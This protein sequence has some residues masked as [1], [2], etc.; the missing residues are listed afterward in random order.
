MNGVI[1]S[2][3]ALLALTKDDSCVPH[4]RQVETMLRRGVRFI[5]FRSKML[6]GASLLEETRLAVDFADQADAVLIVNDSPEVASRSTHGC[7]GHITLRLLQLINRWERMPSSDG[8]FTTRRRPTCQ[9]G[10]PVRYVGLGPVRSSKI[11]RFASRSRIS[12]F[13]NQAVLD[14]IQFI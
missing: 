5:Q 4:H 6:T 2:L 14:Q 3:P 9:I 13:P 12:S 11:T 10:G 7:I 1:Q 8:Q